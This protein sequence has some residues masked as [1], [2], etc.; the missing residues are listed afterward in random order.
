MRPP[1]RIDLFLRASRSLGFE[2]W[3][4][5]PYECPFCHTPDAVVTLSMY[6]LGGAFESTVCLVCWSLRVQVPA[7]GPIDAPWEELREYPPPLISL[8]VAA[9]HE[10][11]ATHPAVRALALGISEAEAAEARH[12]RPRPPLRLVISSDSSEKDEHD[13]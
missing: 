13:S 7:C 1:L 9:G 5:I 8:S 10:W 3:Q 2:G 6:P 4:W 12:W 11:T